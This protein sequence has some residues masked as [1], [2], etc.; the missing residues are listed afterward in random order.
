M[1]KRAA[2]IV[3]SAAVVSAALAVSNPVDVYATENDS[4]VSVTTLDNGI[5]V[6]EV[7]AVMWTNENTAF[8]SSPDDAAVVVPNVGAGLPINVTGIT[9]NGY[10][11]VDLGGQA[12]YI[13]GI[14]LSAGTATAATVPAATESATGWTQEKVY[15]AIMALQSKYPEGMPWDGQEYTRTYISGMEGGGCIGFA[16]QVLEA[17][18]GENVGSIYKGLNVSSVSE[19]KVGDVVHYNPKGGYHVVV[20]LTVGD[21]Y[22]TVVEGNY[23]GTI[24]WGRKITE[25]ELRTGYDWDDSGNR[26]SFDAGYISADTVY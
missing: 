2:K 12:F 24:H 16:G 21:D 23:N 6:T 5:A 22:I 11:R 8:L 17:V 13:N 15:N 9:S 10:F 3:I 1:K 4:V 7:S 20:V 25:K 19:L 18:F 26:I 14:G